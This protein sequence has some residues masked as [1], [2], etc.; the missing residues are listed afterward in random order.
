MA[1]VP[2]PV[3]A[4]QSFVVDAE[5][6]SDAPARAA[7]LDRA[8]GPNRRRKSSE[9]IRR[10]RMPAEGLALVARDGEGSVIATVRLWNVEGGPRR[11]R[12][13]GAGASSRTARRRR[14]HGRQGRRR[15]PRAA[16]GLAGPRARPWRDPARRRPRLLRT[17]RLH[18]STDGNAR[19]AGTV[20]TPPPARP[21][22]R[23]GMALRSRGNDLAERTGG[24]IP[25][26]RRLVP[27]VAACSLPG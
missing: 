20:R 1:A 12:F 2:D 11:A 22:A 8:M 17:L 26:G 25:K 4:C 16:G 18:G 23:R 15:R 6:P 13:S 21:R 10:G 5:R 9:R 27:S 7:L 24:S 3:R 14:A 19:H